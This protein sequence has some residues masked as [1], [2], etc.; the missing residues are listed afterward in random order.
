MKKLFQLLCLAAIAAQAAFAAGSESANSFKDVLF[1]CDVDA[2]SESLQAGTSPNWTDT[3]TGASALHY[4][5]ACWGGENGTQYR[6]VQV[7]L[8]AGATVTARTLLGE[9]V[10]E[11]ALYTASEPTLELLLEAGADPNILT[12][13]DMSPLAIARSMGN[14][15]VERTLLLHG[16]Q[17]IASDQEALKQ[18]EGMTGFIS[19]IDA[20][21]ESNPDATA[22]EFDEALMRYFEMHLSDQRGITAHF[23]QGIVETRE[24]QCCDSD[25]GY[26]IAVPESRLVSSG[27]QLTDRAMGT[28]GCS[29]CSADYRACVSGCGGG[30][31]GNACRLI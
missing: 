29:D 1:Q 23:Q 24:A 13:A 11:R 19:D 7:L 22:D 17:L 3:E 21:D 15:G 18:L 8:D 12:V 6:M 10:L 28:R 2:L 30:W 16:A 20:W 9:S 4:A 31:A 25:S 26:A 27:F 14:E 5:V